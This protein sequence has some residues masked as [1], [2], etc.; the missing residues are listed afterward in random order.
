MSVD[1][2]GRIYSKQ[3]QQLINKDMVFLTEINN[4]FLRRDGRNTAIGTINMTGN[5]FK[6]K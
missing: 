3:K 1:K 4:T 2:F 5:T 6:C